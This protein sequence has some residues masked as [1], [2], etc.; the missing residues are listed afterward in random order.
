[1]CLA[2]HVSAGRKGSHLDR[3][4]G[5]ALLVR[6]TPEKLEEGARFL[7]EFPVVPNDARERLLDFVEV[8]LGDEPAHHDLG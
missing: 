8:Q 5:L 1:M 4:G 2:S 3:R 7:F 6:E